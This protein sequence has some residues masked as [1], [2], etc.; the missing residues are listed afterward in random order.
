MAQ[1]VRRASFP[2][3]PRSAAREKAIL[4]PVVT[5]FVNTK[6]KVQTMLDTDIG[7]EGAQLEGTVYLQRYKS[8]NADKDKAKEEN[9]VQMWGLFQTCIH[10]YLHTATHADYQ[11]WAQTFKAAGDDTRYNTLIEGFC[12]FFTLNVRTT[13]TPDPALAAT[14]EGPYANGK[15]PAPDNSGVY[16]S[17]QQAEQV[18]SVVGIKNAQAAYFQGQTKLMGA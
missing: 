16:P 17:H 18:V 3:R 6:A 5:S 1:P 2:T 11:K 4:T 15:P 10:E 13:V 7:W 9:R 14:V 8:T 12:D